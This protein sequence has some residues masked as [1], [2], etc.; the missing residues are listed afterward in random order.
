MNGSAGN[1]CLPAV[2]FMA[3][4]GYG[5]AVRHGNARYWANFMSH[6]CRSRERAP[7]EM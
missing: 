7:L 4:P 5:I 6:S 3:D 2:L 1:L